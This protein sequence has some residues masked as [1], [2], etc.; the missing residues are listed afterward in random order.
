M[1]S[2]PARD[3]KKSESVCEDGRSHMRKVR[4][5]AGGVYQ[6]A[7]GLFISRLYFGRNPGTFHRRKEE[8]TV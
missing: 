3:A 1:G 5:N 8:E 6:A 4:K 2:G 7:G